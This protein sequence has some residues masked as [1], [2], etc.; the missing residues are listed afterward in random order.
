MVVTWY[1]RTGQNATRGLPGLDL[2]V[3]LRAGRARATGD[4]GAGRALHRR[5]E[6]RAV[7]ADRRVRAGLQSREVRG[8]CVPRLSRG[9]QAA[10]ARCGDA[11]R[12]GERAAST[13]IRAWRDRERT[14][15]QDGAL[16]PCAPAAV[17]LA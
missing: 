8:R 14:Q 2:L 3:A 1:R 16:L 5:P 13:R 4:S 15:P 17:R 7:G 10:R 6:R 9:P 12:A 11:R